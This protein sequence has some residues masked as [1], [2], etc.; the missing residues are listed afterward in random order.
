MYMHSSEE[1]TGTVH[2]GFS[3]STLLTKHLTSDYRF[4]MQTVKCD[5]SDLSD[6]FTFESRSPIF[7]EYCT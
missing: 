5:L 3:R 4:S 1:I 7:T 6:L 2:R